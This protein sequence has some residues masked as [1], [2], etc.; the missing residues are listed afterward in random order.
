VF[1]SV[2]Y[3]SP[4][5]SRLTVYFCEDV[6]ELVPDS[7]NLSIFET[8]FRPA[9]CMHM[10]VMQPKCTVEGADIVMQSNTVLVPRSLSR[11]MSRLENFPIVHIGRDQHKIRGCITFPRP[12]T[13][14][15]IALIRQE[16]LPNMIVRW[17]NGRRRYVVESIRSDDDVC[18][19]KLHY[20]LP[21][22]RKWARFLRDSIFQNTKRRWI[23]RCSPIS[24]R[25]S[26]FSGGRQYRER[27]TKT[28]WRRE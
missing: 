22:Q 18:P 9:A 28:G 8:P 21:T 24:A 11:S 3:D 10:V 17:R 2:E 14:P 19:S 15:R 1:L 13:I 26:G 7:S 25:K 6:G 4:K 27:N 12:V 23:V 16:H 5:G 20:P